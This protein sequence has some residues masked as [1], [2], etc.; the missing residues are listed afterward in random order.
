MVS[1]S[2]LKQGYSAE[3]V[4]RAILEN[5]PNI[6]ARKPGHEADYAN[7]TV[8]AALMHPDVLAHIKAA[9]QASSHHGMSQ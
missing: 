6:E 7:R 3:I 5:S 2:L 8:Q 9:A 1:K 4:Q